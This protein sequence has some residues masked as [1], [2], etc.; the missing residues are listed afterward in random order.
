MVCNNYRKRVTAHRIG[1][2]GRIS[3]RVALSLGLDVPD[4]IACTPDGRWLAIS[5]HFTNSALI[6]DC[7]GRLTPRTAPVGRLTGMAYP[8]GLR[9]SPD[10][11]YAFVAY[12]GAPVLHVFR[13]DTGQWMGDHAPLRSVKVL[14]DEVFQRGRTNDAEGG[15][16][17]VDIDNSGTILVVTCEEQP[18]AFFRV[19]DLI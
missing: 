10:G 11:R 6:Y 12:A 3:N 9:F 8:H 16:K 2:D 14:S 13:S 18:L 19:A 15:P 5:D 4:G 7:Q 1:R 17:G